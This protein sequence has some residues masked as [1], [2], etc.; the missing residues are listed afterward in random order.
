MERVSGQL[1][2]PSENWVVFCK[3]MNVLTEMLSM[4]EPHG[5]VSSEIP[6]ILLGVPQKLAN[7]IVH[8]LIGLDITANINIGYAKELVE[9]ALSYHYK[10]PMKFIID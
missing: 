10:M 9:E 8:H 5:K 3:H 6:A 4:V 1:I 2:I 7:I